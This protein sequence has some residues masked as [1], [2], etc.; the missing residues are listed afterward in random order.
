MFSS[1]TIYW[2]ASYIFINVIYV[3]E[4][5]SFS[6]LYSFHRNIDIATLEKTSSIPALFLSQTAVLTGY[7]WVAQCKIQKLKITEKAIY[8]VSFPLTLIKKRSLPQRVLVASVISFSSLKIC[9]AFYA[10][11]CGLTALKYTSPPPVEKL[12]HFKSTWTEF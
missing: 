7:K 6:S 9:N 5:W 1:W 10:I 11:Q 8:R 12:F 4:Y 3:S 2:L